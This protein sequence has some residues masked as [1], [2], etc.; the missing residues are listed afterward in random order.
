MCLGTRAR[1]WPHLSLELSNFGFT[2]VEV[3]LGGLLYYWKWLHLPLELTFWALRIVPFPVLPLT[4]F[5]P[6]CLTSAQPYP[7]S[8]SWYL[9]DLLFK[10]R[11]AF[12]PSLSLFR[13]WSVWWLLLFV[14]LNPVRL[15][16]SLG[17]SLHLIFVSYVG[18][19]HMALPIFDELNQQKGNFPQPSS[20]CI[21]GFKL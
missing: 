19:N 15:S 1:W 10:Y 3:A 14:F 11:F 4:T 21:F 12:N 2:Y 18:L 5:S 7:P 16:L 20:H 8:C 9:H 17:K 13:T 6:P